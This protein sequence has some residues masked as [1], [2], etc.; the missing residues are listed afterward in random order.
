MIKISPI[1]G[2]AMH[3]YYRAI[4]SWGSPIGKRNAMKA[5]PRQREPIPFDPELLT[6]LPGVSPSL[7]P[8][9]AAAEDDCKPSDYSVTN[10]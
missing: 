6:P 5:P 9:L 2:E 3:A 1:S 4:S 8:T 7:T 10:W